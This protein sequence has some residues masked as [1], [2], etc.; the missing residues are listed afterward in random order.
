MHAL[1]LWFDTEFSDR[2]CKEKPVLLTTSP[3]EGQT[4]WAQT[5][6]LGAVSDASQRVCGVQLP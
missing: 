4:H 3:H 2:F 1:V 6:A 5:G